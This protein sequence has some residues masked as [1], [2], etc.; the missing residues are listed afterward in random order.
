MVRNSTK[1]LDLLILL[2]CQDHVDEVLYI[3]YVMEKVNED[4]VL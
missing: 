2:E 4:P 1:Q 3:L